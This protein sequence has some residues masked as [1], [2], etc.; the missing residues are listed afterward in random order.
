M[1][2]VWIRCGS[3][4]RYYIQRRM[5]TLLNTWPRQEMLIRHSIPELVAMFFSYVRALTASVVCR[6]NDHWACAS[7]RMTKVVRLMKA[8]APRRCSLRWVLM[9]LGGFTPFGAP[10]SGLWR[11]LP[12]A[13][14]E[15]I[16]LMR[17]S[18]GDQSGLLDPR[19][20]KWPMKSESSVFKSKVLWEWPSDVMMTWYL[21]RKERARFQLLRTMHWITL[22]NPVLLAREARLLN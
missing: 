12:H 15:R 4:V 16:H 11:I 9:G 19:R 3:I 20:V 2:T 1:D 6:R 14:D 8:S 10:H 22:W 18:P 5:R 13:D 7:W 17:A 21:L